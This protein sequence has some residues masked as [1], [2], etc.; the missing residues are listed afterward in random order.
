MDIEATS[1]GH[2]VMVVQLLAKTIIGDTK[3]PFRLT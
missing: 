2:T 1:L 3:S